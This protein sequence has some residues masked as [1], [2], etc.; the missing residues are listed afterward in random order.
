MARPRR[1]R[2]AARSRWAVG[3]ALLLVLGAAAVARPVRVRTDGSS[4]VVWLGAWDRGSVSFTNS[5]TGGPVVIDFGLRTGFDDVR[6]RTDEKTEDYYTDGTYRINR[7]LRSER[8]RSLA[9]CSMVG[10]QVTLRARTLRVQDSCLS[11]ELL[12]PPL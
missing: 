7:R 8:S 11:L 12:W 5:V 4:R 2:P 1:G 3:A 10:M 6:M 9:Y